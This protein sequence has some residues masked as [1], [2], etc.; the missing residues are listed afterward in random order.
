MAFTPEQLS[1]YFA[2]IENYRNNLEPNLSLAFD[3][4]SG[5]LDQ[6]PA[7]TNHYENQ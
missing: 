3:Y 5:K 4:L 2:R 1:P 7:F 6:L